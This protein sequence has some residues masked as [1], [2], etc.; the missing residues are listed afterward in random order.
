MTFT[1]ALSFLGKQVKVE[2][3]RPLGSKHP[4]W[5]HV[6]L[7]NYG[8]VPGTK[9]ADGEEIDVYVSGVPEPVDTFYG[10]CVA[11]VHRLNDDDEKLIVVPTGQTYSD[12]QIRRFTD[13][14]EQYFES[15]IVR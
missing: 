15:E 10:E 2:I 3:D 12:E 9:A 4:E 8:F 14:Q 7:V 1:N 6:Y 5:Q 13:F 11:V